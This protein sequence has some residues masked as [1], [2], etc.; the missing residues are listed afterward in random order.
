MGEGRGGGKS[1][2]NLNEQLFSIFASRFWLYAAHRAVR[3]PPMNRPPVIRQ[4]LYLWALVLGLWAL[5]V[6]AFAGQLLFTAN[7]PASEALRLSLRDWL[8]WAVLAP[9]VVWLAS[10]FPLVRGKLALSVPIHL[11]ACMLALLACELFAPTPPS[12][13]GPPQ[14]VAQPRFRG[15]REDG[16]PFV[17]GPRRPDGQPFNEP[18]P[19]EGPPLDQLRPVLEQQRRG[20]LMRAKFNI[21]IYWIVVSLV[22][23]LS[24]YQRS[25]ERERKA[26]ELEARLADAKLQALRMQLHPH[27]LFNTLNA[28]ATLVH[29]DARAADEMI[30][31]LSELLRA[32]LDTSEQEIPLRRELDFLNRYLEIQQVRFGERLR[33]EK[34]IDAAALDALVPTLILQPLVENAIRHGIE[35]NPAAG[36]VTIRARLNENGALHLTVRDSGS[37]SKPHDKASSGIGLANTRGRLLE[38]YGNRA[39]LMLNSDAEGGF[40]VELEIPFHEQTDLNAGEL[41]TKSLGNV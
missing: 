2:T 14:G 23:T 38:L 11:G 9:V 31:N 10:Q 4:Q 32:T 5:L 19:P 16:P 41:E 7:L 17:P 12:I 13:T 40:A 1:L 6:L 30:T 35:P 34:E 36:V 33:V 8:P 24:F 29:K 15:G 18:F 20:I 3:L 27:F 26:L 25:E 37:G 21:P 28:I 22:H 39:R